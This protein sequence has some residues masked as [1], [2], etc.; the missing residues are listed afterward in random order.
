MS[1]IEGE[2]PK[3]R[4]WLPYW[5][6]Q[7]ILAIVFWV[8]GWWFLNFPFNFTSIGLASTLI[9]IGI[10]YYIRLKQPN[11]L[12]QYSIALAISII[13]FGAISW[14]LLNVPIERAAASTVFILLAISFGYYIRVR[15]NVKINRALY[16]SLSA[17]ILGFIFWIV[18]MT[19]MRIVRLLIGLNIVDGIFTL[20]ML[21]VCYIAGGY[22]GDWIGKR[23]GYRIPLYP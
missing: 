11:W 14:F 13:A 1:A 2:K 22:I 16:I 23:R 17:L 10:L 5:L 3:P 8:A 6:I 15:P 21:I 19:S 9:L 18:L 20:I 12:K 7:I 4:W